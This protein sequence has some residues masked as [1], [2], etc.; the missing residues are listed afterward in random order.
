MPFKIFKDAMTSHV[1]AMF[2]GQTHLFRANVDGDA[3]WEMY[4]N[5]FPPG[6]NEIYRERREFDCSCCRHFIR[7]FGDVVALVDNEPVSIWDFEVGGRY[8]PVVASLSDMVHAAL[9]RDVFVTREDRVG[10]ANNIELMEGIAHTWHHFSIDL[11]AGLVSQS[12]FTD[13]AVMA[14]LRD[15]KAVFK[16]SLE[17]ITLDALETVLDLIAEQALYRGDE[18]LPTLTKF[19]ELF[20]EYH[21]LSASVKD[22]YCWITSVNVGGAVATI[23]NHSIGTLLNDLSG[24]MDVDSALRRWESVMAPANYKRPKAVFTKA[25]VKA[26]EQAVIDMGLLDSLP[27]RHARITDITVNNVIWADPDAARAMGGGVFDLLRDEVEVDPSRFKDVPGLPVETFI[28]LVLTSA[29]RVEVLLENSHAPNLVSLIAPEHIGAK[30]ITKWSN[31]FTWAYAGNTTDSPLREMVRA[32]GGR[33]DG[34]FRFSHSWNHRGQRNASLMDLHVFMPGNTTPVVVTKRDCNYGNEQRVGWNHRAHGRS[35]GV[36]DVDYVAPAAENYIPVENITFPHIH[37]MPDGVYVCKIHNWK[38]RNPNLGG[39][40]AEIEFSG[41]VFEYEHTKPL[42]NHEWVTVAVVTLNHG[43]FTIEHH[44]P[45][46]TSSKNLWDMTTNKFYPVSAF[47]HSP[48]YW[49]GQVGIGNKHYMFILPAAINTERLNGFFNE[50][51][52]NGLMQHK[53]VFEALGNRMRVEPS[54]EQLSGLGFSSTKRSSIIVKYDG[55]VA[56]V[57]F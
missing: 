53:R 11:P 41:Q 44:L 32:A 33:V 16:R 8:A 29:K 30:P 48:N 12:T 23:R 15:A 9:V 46:T 1:Q 39:F 27:R 7:R 50:Y 14:R 4:L 2:A 37:N 34:A 49:D 35:G 21:A 52:D 3:M 51:L 5:S 47:M 10:T 38:E 40:R 22:N 31:N 28:N 20:N 13:D 56:R 19:K 6:T 36:Q 54:D 24:G 55:K 45:M 17:E 18:W 42:Q 57:V 43:Q 26:A 25:M